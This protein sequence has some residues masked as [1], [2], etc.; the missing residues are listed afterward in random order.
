MNEM[1]RIFTL[2]GADGPWGDYSDILLHGMVDYQDDAPDRVLLERCG[3]YIPPVSVPHGDVIVT[4]EARSALVRAFPDLQF[5]EVEKKRIVRLDWHKWDQTK[6]EPKRYPRGGE[7]ENYI[8]KRRHSQKTANAMGRLS[9]LRQTLI[10]GVQVEGSSAVVA[11]ELTG[12]MAF[13]AARLG[14]Y[15][16][17]RGELAD[18]LGENYGQYVRL[19]QVVVK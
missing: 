15:T 5:V 16:Y 12:A 11:H 9:A 13:T 17:V 1:R 4:D 7:P 18:W 2:H 8:L 10:P 3:P 14:G 19:E 6:D